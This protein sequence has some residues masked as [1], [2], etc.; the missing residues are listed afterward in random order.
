MKDNLPTLQLIP[1]SEDERE[2]M[3]QEIQ[4]VF[5]KSFEDEFGP[6][7]QPVIPREDILESLNAQ[8]AAAFFAFD[9]DTRVGGTAV[10]IDE[11]T[12]KNSLDLL[13]VRPDVQS[14]GCGQ[15]IWQEIEKRYPKTKVW[16]THTPYFDRRNVHFYVN[17]LG[18]QIVEFYNSKHPDPHRKDEASGLPEGRASEFFRFEK[19]MDPA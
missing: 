10:V 15:R 16:E 12:G 14:R 13:Y 7:D 8:G 2:L 18:F 4:Q 6:W 5:Q 11:K 1:V 3:I 17:R 9:G 19:Q